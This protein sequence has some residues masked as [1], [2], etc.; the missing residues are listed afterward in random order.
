MRRRKD[1]VPVTAGEV[2]N[3]V[4]LPVVAAADGLVELDAAPVALPEVRTA[5]V[6]QHAALH[7]RDLE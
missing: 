4:D 2:L 6:P 5:V 7:P 3:A 1:A